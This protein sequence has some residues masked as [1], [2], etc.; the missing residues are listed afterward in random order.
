MYAAASFVIP[1]AGRKIFI[2]SPSLFR[3]RDLKSS[4]ARSLPEK[5]TRRKGGERGK[6]GRMADI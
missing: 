4:E 5:R 2:D 1:L 3:L 6:K